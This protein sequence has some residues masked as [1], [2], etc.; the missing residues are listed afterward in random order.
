MK[1]CPKCG[2]QLM[3][4]AVVCIGCGCSVS[5]VKKPAEPRESSALAHIA[6]VFAFVMPLIGILLGIIGMSKYSNEH[7]RKKSKSAIL[8][9]LSIL[10]LY[11][12]IFAVCLQI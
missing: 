11:V 3:D 9:A 5:R 6:T 8:F 1:Y 7:L 12:T 2:K 10:I 4:D